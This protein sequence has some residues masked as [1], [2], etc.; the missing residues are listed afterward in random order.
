[1]KLNKYMHYWLWLYLI[2][3]DLGYVR[4]GDGYKAHTDELGLKDTSLRNNTRTA[5]RF[6]FV[7]LLSF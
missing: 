2:C 6:I 7:F 4:S 3:K 1:M 5:K